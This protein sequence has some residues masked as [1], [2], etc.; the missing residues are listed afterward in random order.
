VWPAADL[1]TLLATTGSV[2]LIAKRLRLVYPAPGRDAVRAL[3]EV[4]PARAGGL[5]VE[6]PLTLADPAGQPS[7][8]LAAM[9]GR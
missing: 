6:P 4:K 2:G 7:A 9:T 1:A 8:E 3:L 5:S